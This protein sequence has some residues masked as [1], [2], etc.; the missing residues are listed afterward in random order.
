[1]SSTMS[2]T[3]HIFG[4]AGHLHKATQADKAWNP[5]SWCDMARC[6]QCL[7]DDPAGFQCN[8]WGSGTTTVDMTGASIGWWTGL[9]CSDLKRQFRDCTLASFS[10]SF[11]YCYVTRCSQTQESYSYSVSH[12]GVFAGFMALIWE[13]TC[14]YLQKWTQHAQT[15]HIANA[16]EAC[17]MVFTEKSK[18]RQVTDVCIEFALFYSRKGLELFFSQELKRF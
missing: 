9:I 3:A 1:M 16:I 2:F 14:C 5:E 12:N 11:D 4:V 17:I 10:R 15:V 18:N 7:E 13:L 8:S 6:G